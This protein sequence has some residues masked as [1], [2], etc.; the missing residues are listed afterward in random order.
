MLKLKTLFIILVVALMAPVAGAAATNALISHKLEPETLHY[1]VMFK[2]GL[3]NKQAGSATLT[4]S[5]GK[6]NYKATLAAAS[7]PWADKM[8]RV[9]DTLNGRMAYGDFR[10]L[11]YEKIANEGSERK[12]DIVRYDYSGDA[13]VSADCVRKVY[14]KGELKVDETRSLHS[15]KGAVDMLTSFYY[16]RSLPFERWKPGHVE[17]IDIFSGKQKELLSIKYHGVTDVDLDG[18]TQKAYHV[19]FTFTSGNGVKTSDDM[20]AWISLD[21][22][23]IP[24][25]LE[26]KL[27]VGKVH[28]IYVP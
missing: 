5:H 25:R 13:G 8:Y 17:K 26:G 18:A 16:M 15:D 21:A 2:W 1:K 11:F 14:K 27:P 23:R 19:S 6:S 28:C 12:H 9:R 22:R 20:D 24:L 10:P 7:A 4:L 3:I